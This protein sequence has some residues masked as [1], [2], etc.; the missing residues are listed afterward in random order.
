MTTPLSRRDALRLACLAA[1]S[2][3]L[4][5]ALCADEPKKKIPIGLEL[6]SVR[7]QLKTDFTGTIEAVGKMGYTGVEF[8]GY[9]GWDK[10]PQELRKL[11]DDNGLKCCGT[12]THLPTLQGDELEKTIELHKIL[13]NKFLICP[14]VHI[15]NGKGWHDLAWK[16]NDISARAAEYGMLVGYHS[17]AEDFKKYNGTTGWEIFFDNTKNAVVHQLDTGNAIDGGADPLALIKKYPGRTKTTH[18][19]ERGGKA[20][21]PVGEGTI[22]WKTM[23]AAYESVGGTEWY[24]VEHETS[25]DP[26]KTVKA[27]LENMHKMG[28]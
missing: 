3:A 28:K 15:T 25:P 23:F 12:H 24:I 21:T 8:A 22:D 10:K 7:D 18:I 20:D 4:P 26:L 9:Y 6:F 13:G 27:C 2:S 16:F 17:H 5:V 11:L 14:N 1:A 19:K